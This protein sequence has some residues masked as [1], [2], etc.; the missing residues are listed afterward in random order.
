MN[1]A[2]FKASLFM[3]AGIVDHETGT[4]DMRRLSG[5]WRYMP[6]TAVLAMVSAGAMAG[7]PLF[8]G[9]LSKEMFFA[10]ALEIGDRPVLGAVAPIAVTLGSIFSVAYSIRFI[11]DVFFN[12][13]PR[14]LP[15]VPHE[16][17]RYMKLP[18]EVLVIIVIAV[19]IA[20]AY[21]VA[22]LLDVAAPQVL[23]DAVPD[24]SLAL[25]HGFTLPLAMSGVALAG[26]A[27]MYWLLQR[28]YDLHMHVPAAFAGRHFFQWAYDGAIAGATRV[29]A[30]LEN[31]S[32]QRYLAL[33]V[34]TFAAL[35][36]SAFVA[37]GYSA[38]TRP[39][40]PVAPLDAAVGL[41][42][43]AAALGAVRFHRQR[44]VGVILAGVVGLSAAIAFA[45]FSA[46]DLALTQLAVEVVTTVLLL[47]GLALLPQSS[48]AESTRFRRMRDATL[49]IAAG[50]GV[51]A[52][53]YAA[54]T[55]PHESIA[56]YF[57]QSSVPEGGG[58]NVVNVILV[59]FRGFD[60]FGEITVLAIAAVGAWMLMENV[61]MGR[62]AATGPDRNPLML[63]A[64]ARLL[65][66]FALMI[67]AYIFLRGHNQPGGGF[68]A[69]LIAAA[70]LVMQYL[71]EGLERTLSRM[72]IDFARLLAAGILLAAGTGVASLVAGAPFLTSAHGHPRVPLLG[73]IP[74]ASAMAFDLG[75]FMTVLGAT[76]LA[77]T[78]LAQASARP[79]SRAGGHL[80]EALFV[81]ARLTF[82]LEFA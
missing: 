33:A 22:A 80:M 72:R 66:P 57:L 15:R 77:L 8:N 82:G 59:D 74:L 29:T 69:G 5:L 60:T 54:L 47:M 52:L 40:T 32:L 62:R 7:V 48:P 81:I 21:T 1:H 24:Y 79:A 36:A 38:G 3:A 76:M 39:I 11:H 17:P 9:F 23:G 53:A 44:L 18:V 46:P 14:D 28:K 67:A 68:I 20:P 78:V 34:A 71:A 35:G 10:E 75:V 63:S 56:W 73:E 49:A 51:A 6:H 2:T 31:G 13:E 55:R 64:A 42:A 50:G 37:H 65:L 16:P 41:I 43:I 12:G 25:W 30:W 19:G 4:R 27:I 70:A 26:G 58:S 61:R 45:R